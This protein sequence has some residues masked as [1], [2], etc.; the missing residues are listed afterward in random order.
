L[1]KAPARIVQDLQG[2]RPRGAPWIREPGIPTLPESTGAERSVI[3][4][5]LVTFSLALP[6]GI[7]VEAQKPKPDAAKSIAAGLAWLARHQN[8]D[9]SWG[10]NSLMQRCTGE[11]PCYDKRGDMTGHFDEGLTGLAVLGF[12]RSGTLAGN[13]PKIVDPVTG[14]PVDAAAVVASGLGW[15]KKIQKKSG[16]FC[17][18]RSFV[19]NDSAATLAMI[20]GY[21]VTR[22]DAWKDSAAKGVDFIEK[23]QRPSPTGDGLWGWRYASRQE[24]EK[25]K[26]AKPSDEQEEAWKKELHESDVSATGWAV[27]VLAAASDARLDVKEDALKGALDYLNFTTKTNGLVGYDTSENAGAK[28]TG[29]FD[30]YQYHV[31]T[32]CSIGVLIRLAASRD[33]TNA[34]YDLAVKEISKDLPQFSGDPLSIDYYYWYHGTSAMNRL[35]GTEG[36][37]KAKRKVAEAWNK[38]VLDALTAAQDRTKD[39]CSQ[40]GWVIPDRWSLYA[41]GPVY[42]TAMGVLT[43][44]AIRKK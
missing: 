25:M 1:E 36:P 40:G 5:F 2:K 19:Y 9:G 43:L 29:P 32:M 27:A 12:L 21:A 3:Q 26:P 30:E 16:S 11:K 37:K 23:A 22:D 4:A 38:A 18:Q 7:P 15:L 20:E 6:G 28:V 17:R 33:T 13:A 24:I 31:A 44:E 39:A 41:A 8:P 42:S 14:K 34:F 35:E 10:G